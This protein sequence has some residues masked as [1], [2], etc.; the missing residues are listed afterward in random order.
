MKIKIEIDGC[1]VETEMDKEKI[2]SS[3][4]WYLFKTLMLSSEERGIYEVRDDERDCDILGQQHRLN[5]L[6]QER[7]K[8]YW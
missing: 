4:I 6:E 7:V 8:N 5:E 3:S 2:T 1:K